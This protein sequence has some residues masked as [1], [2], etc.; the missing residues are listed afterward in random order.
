MEKL[1]GKGVYRGIA[2]GELRYFRKEGIRAEQNTITDVENE[3][4]RFRQAQQKELEELDRLY[5]KA[6]KEVGEKDAQIFQIHRMMLEDEEFICSVEN[7]VR[8]QNVN[9]EYAVRKAAEAVEKTLASMEDD[10]LRSRSADIKEVFGGLIGY[11]NGTDGTELRLEN[12]VILAADDLSPSETIKLDKSKILAFVTAQGSSNSHTSILAR[13]MNI[14]AAVALGDMLEPGCEGKSAVLDGETGTLY[15]EPDA[16]TLETYQLKK[17]Q[18]K[19][20][21]SELEKLRGQ[22]NVAYDGR[23]V[24]IYANVGN[25]GDVKSALENDAGGIG[26][27]RSEFLYLGRESLPTEEEQFQIYKTALEDMHGKEVV[28]RT[29]DI[30]ADKQADYLDLPKEENPAMGCRAIRLCLTHPEIFKTQLRA[31]YRAS[32]YGKLLI[33]L[34]MITSVQEIRDCKQ[35][36]REVKAELLAQ[37]VPFNP[38]IPLGIMV[39]TPAAAIISD[40]LAQEAD[41]FSIGTNDLTQYTLA[42]DRQNAA[43]ERFFDPHHP[44]VLQLIQTVAENAHRHGIWVGICGELGADE[45]LTELFLN[46]GINELSVSPPRILPLRKCVRRL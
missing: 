4:L 3:L 21:A 19:E 24:R 13:S 23:T 42:M 37:N 25:L 29:L 18:Q 39:E 1:Q 8:N 17:K 27:F 41:F 16:E 30:G 34:P 46:M 20:E 28:I 33:M 45:E 40:K 5:E 35:I 32:I 26:L 44:A 38:D 36:F 11:L 15:I 22:D 14:P 7:A 10:Y 2:I 12:P 9:V 31:L 6:R 43:L